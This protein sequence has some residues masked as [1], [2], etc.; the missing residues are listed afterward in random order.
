[1]ATLGTVFGGAFLAMGGEKKS[2]QSG[3]PINATS[4]EE[5]AFITYVKYQLG[6]KSRKHMHAVLI[7]QSRCALMSSA[8][9]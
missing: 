2:K 4:K 9:I 5:E 3:P 1:M 7:T 6:L 8:F